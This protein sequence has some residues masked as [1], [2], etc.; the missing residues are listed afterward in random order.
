MT[1]ILDVNPE[2]VVR[3]GQNDSSL[4][5][6]DIEERNKS[7]VICNIPGD[8]GGRCSTVTI[9]QGIDYLKGLTGVCGVAA[10]PRVCARIS[11]SYNAAIWLCN[12]NAWYI[13]PSCSYLG[14]YAEDIVS[15]CAHVDFNSGTK[16]WGTQWS[17]TVNGQEF[18]TDN[19][20]V[21]VGVDSC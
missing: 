19:Y 18:D 7:G 12:D 16:G 5:A 10:G 13:Q 1:Q 8:K 3:L 6:R 14:T 4:S 11:C 21:I 15:T 9:M 2:F 20:N 17:D